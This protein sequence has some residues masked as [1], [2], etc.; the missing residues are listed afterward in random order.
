MSEYNQLLLRIVLLSLLL[1]FVVP[2]VQAF[3]NSAVIVS[4]RYDQPMDR[5]HAAGM[6]LDC[7]FWAS[8]LGLK[9]CSYAPHIFENN[10]KTYVRWEKSIG[11]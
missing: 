8:P 2:A 4:L 7:S 11:W 3:W 1:S 5:I 6:P 9:A 10:G